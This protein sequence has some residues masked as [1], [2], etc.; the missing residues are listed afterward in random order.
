MGGIVLDLAVKAAAFVAI[1][2]RHIDQCS[3]IEPVAQGGVAA[4]TV[5]VDFIFAD[6][7]PGPVPIVKG[8]CAI[9]KNMAA[10][11]GPFNGFMSKPS[12]NG[13]SKTV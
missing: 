12:A 5:F 1:G 11:T 6:G 3:L 9:I 7:R 13:K 10:A 2:I 4:E 8:D